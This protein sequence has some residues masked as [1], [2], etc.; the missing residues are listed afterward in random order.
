MPDRYIAA[1]IQLAGIEA[2]KNLIVSLKQSG[3]FDICYSFKSRLKSEEKLLEKKNKKII[4]KN[5]NYKLTDIT[6]V[7]GLRFITLFRI[8]MALIFDK[9]IDIIAH[10]SDLK[11]NFFRKDLIK[12]II[13]YHTSPHD[14]IPDMIKEIVRQKGIPIEVQ[15]I[16]VDREYSSIHIVVYYDGEVKEATNGANKYYLPVEIQIRTAF[17][18]AWGEIDHKYKYK[19]NA[20]SDNGI[21]INGRR[22][23]SIKRHLVVLKKFSDACAEY[24]DAIFTDANYNDSEEIDRQEVVSVRTDN[25][26]LERF[27]ELGVPDEM[28]R[29]YKAAREKRI[30]AENEEKV[31]KCSG[32]TIFLE[33][34]SL[35]EQI[36]LTIEKDKI[37][38]EKPKNY[39]LY[40]YSKMNQAVSLLSTN[41]SD[42]V[43]SALN[44]YKDLNGFYDGFPLLKMRIGQAYGKSNYTELAIENLYEA[45]LSLKSFERDGNQFTDKLPKTDYDH[46]KTHLPKIYGFNLWRK[47]EKIKS[48]PEKIDEVLHLLHNAYYL[49]NEIVEYKEG[50]NVEIDTY[51]NL[52]YYALDLLQLK[53]AYPE[54]RFDEGIFKAIGHLIKKIEDKKTLTEIQ[55]ID[56]LD[57]LLRAYEY[58][59]DE[60]KMRLMLGKIFPLAEE[61]NTAATYDRE[62]LADI[63]ENANRVKKAYFNPSCAE[64]R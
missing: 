29:A 46:I 52:L 2:E 11:P 49:T 35:F 44:I 14:K 23:D 48:Y 18:D 28:I 8:E 39:L 60:D 61:L 57:T 56:L 34:A 25:E 15:T 47:Y 38:E 17:E 30:N 51:N 10:K 59:S 6:D 9:I 40:Y 43:Q 26:T 3:I 19:L 53:K 42:N 41:Q 33:A 7:I 12:E 22:A 27:R 37:S 5:K 62:M 13:V 58:S 20:I 4:E 63:L 55:D 45:Y 24:A 1:R 32:I 31:R 36:A 54:K 21:N 16:T 64:S 50:E